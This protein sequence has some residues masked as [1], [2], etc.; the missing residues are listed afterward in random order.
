MVPGTPNERT[1]LAW[2]RTALSLMVAAVAVVRLTFG[3]LGPVAL[4]VLACSLPLAAWVLVESRLRYR[5]RAEVAKRRR[6]HDG[7]AGLVLTIV[8]ASLAL[9]EL[10]AIVHSA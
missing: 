4:V 1:A 9:T 8:L 7:L 3:D 10:A 6:A 2:Q 5:D